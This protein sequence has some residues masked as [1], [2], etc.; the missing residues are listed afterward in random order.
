MKKFLLIIGIIFL[1]SFTKSVHA[2]VISCN[3]T[4]SEINTF[5][6]NETVYVKSDSNITVAATQVDIYI[7]NDINNWTNGT[8]LT[9]V[10]G[11]K[12]TNTTNS[13]GYL[14]I[15]KTWSPTLSVAKY[16]I[17]VDV[18][19][20]GVYNSTVDYVDSLT[21]TGFEVLPVPVP[22]IT[23]AIGSN[24][25]ANHNWYVSNTSYN[26]MLQ[27]KINASSF[28]DV[29]IKSI[30]LVASGSGNDKTGIHYVTLISD[31]NANGKFDQGEN[32]LAFGEYSGDDGFLVF[33]LNNG[34]GYVVQAN[35]TIYMLILY[36]MTNSSSNGDTY[37]FK[38]SSVA[39][40]GSTTGRVASTPGIPITSATKTAVAAIV[41][42]TSTAIT[43]TSIVASSATS[44]STSITT[45]TVSPTSTTVPT[46]PPSGPGWMN[47]VLIAGLIPVAVIAVILAFIFLKRRKKSAVEFEE[48]KE[49]WNKY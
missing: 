4:G 24:S 49:K 48:L 22:T 26:E 17:V 6:A 8:N 20:D 31:D 5:Y 37:S 29:K 11:G 34:D 28:E 33:N 46:Q 1:T 9:D 43:S 30:G 14:E 27:L 41:T 47:I 7:V 38:V 18:N 3:E 16:D 25:P 45:T 2:Q 12:K 15:M 10:S 13:S 39:A 23:F 40:T 42:T 19:R 21:A 36:S 32:I 44:T 35:K